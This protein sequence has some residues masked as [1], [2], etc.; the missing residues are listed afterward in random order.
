M[1][2]LLDLA[3]GGC[4]ALPVPTC[5][6]LHQCPHNLSH[7]LD[8]CYLESILHTQSMSNF[9]VILAGPMMN[10]DKNFTSSVCGCHNKR[11]EHSSFVRFASSFYHFDALFY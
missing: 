1:H 7:I 4:A 2:C 6:H 5:Y 9:Q 10:Q 3:G 8:G 11:R